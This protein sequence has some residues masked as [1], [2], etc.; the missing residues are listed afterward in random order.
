MNPANPSQPSSP[1]APPGSS[2]LQFPL[3]EVT[4]HPTVLWSVCDPP[5]R[6]YEPYRLLR[7]R[8]LHHPLRHSS[9]VV[10]SS[11]PADGKSTVS[12]NLAGVMA[13]RGQRVLLMDCDLRRSKLSTTLGIRAQCGLDAILQGA[14][15]EEMIF[16]VSSLPN[17]SILL[18]GRSEE[19]PVDILDS[20]EFGALMERLRTEFDYI[21]IDSPP[22]LNLADFPVLERLCDATVFV[23]RPGYTEISL[24]QD[25]LATLNNDKFLGTVINQ[26]VEWWLWKSSSYYQYYKD[27]DRSRSNNAV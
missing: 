16:S 4:P 15:P 27:Y 11:C 5:A 9:L 8:L 26:N 17:L 25:S 14:S 22:I 12:I 20:P 24:L 13:K 21:V 23:V 6:L 1:A 2:R 19:N 18:A 7:T 10:T 3:R